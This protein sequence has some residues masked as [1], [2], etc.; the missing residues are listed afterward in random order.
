MI[1]KEDVLEALGIGSSTS[2]WILPSLI[3]FGVGALVGAS[4]AILL[5]P[6]SGAEMREELMDRGRD[7]VNR[8]K[9]VLGSAPGLGSSS[10][11]LGSSQP[12][13]TGP[14]Y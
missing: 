10:S 13:S 7:L 9:E 5:A 11:T 4:V 1:N 3:G 8:G 14:K 2:D 6:K 12:T